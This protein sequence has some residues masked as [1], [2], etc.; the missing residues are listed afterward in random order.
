MKKFLAGKK[1]VDPQP[2]YT[3]MRGF[4]GVPEPV[5]AGNW[6]S[7]KKKKPHM[8]TDRDDPLPCATYNNIITVRRRR[9]WTRSHN[10]FG[11]R[12]R[13]SRPTASRRVRRWSAYPAGR[14]ACVVSP[15]ADLFPSHPSSSVCVCIQQSL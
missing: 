4:L 14:G 7:K 15:V 8:N 10:R 11:R 5:L 1:N 9:R 6:I 13:P 3:C 12:R 2:M